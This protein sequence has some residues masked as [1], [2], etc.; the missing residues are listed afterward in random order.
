V[1]ELC[2]DEFPIADGRCLRFSTSAYYDWSKRLPSALQRDNERLLW[3]YPTPH[4][5]RP[6]TL[7]PGRHAGRS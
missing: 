6:G 3:P 1:I 2:R 4:Q 7:A 5:D